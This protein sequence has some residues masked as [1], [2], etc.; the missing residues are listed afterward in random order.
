MTRRDDVVLLRDML[1][2]GK[3][4]FEASRGRSRLD[5]D[6]DHIW[7]L[8]LFKC[9]EIIGEAAGRVSA[10]T[11]RKMSELPW[12]QIIAM[13]NRIVHGYFDIDY[14]QV[15]NAITKELPP[16]IESIKGFLER[17]K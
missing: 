16:L 17:H 1:D 13:R 4:A 2:A 3:E 6:R 8:G 10:E 5:L 15:W 9:V 12:E 14:D 11:R 7:A